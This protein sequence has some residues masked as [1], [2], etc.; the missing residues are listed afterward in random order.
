MKVQTFIFAHKQEIILDYLNSDKFKY[1]PNVKYLLLGDSDC[2]LLSDKDNVIVAR[3]L[4]I[5]REEYPLFVSY[6]G[7]YSLWKNNLIDDDTDYINLFEYDICISINFDEVFF[8]ELRSFPDVIFFTIYTMSSPMFLLKD[9][10]K[11]I[12]QHYL[13]ERDLDIWKYFGE[14]NDKDKSY[15]SCSTNMTLSKNSFDEFMTDFEKYFELV[16]LSEFPGHEFEQSVSLFMIFN[17]KNISFLRNILT[18]YE[19]NSHK[20]TKFARILNY[21]TIKNELLKNKL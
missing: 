13:K 9:W 2:S 12:R 18:H 21:D 14:K 1:L 15:W 4:P 16:K 11:N 7:W 20:N 3:N 19:A 10:T 17:N 8:R 6:T 5:N